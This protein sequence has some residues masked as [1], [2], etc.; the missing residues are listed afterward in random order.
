MA[1]KVDAVTA[2]YGQVEVLHQISITIDTGERVGL[3][4]PN[5]HGKTTLLRAVSGLICPRAGQIHFDSNRIDGVAPKRIVGLGLIHVPQANT[6]FRTMTVLENL[7]LGAYSP[8]AWSE[9]RA[10][11]LRVFELFPLLA[12]RRDQL[13][14]TLSGGE[15]QMLAIGAGLM[16]APTMLMLDEP[17]LGL[18][19]RVKDTLAR[20]I[21][22]IAESG[23]SLLIV[24]Q[25]VELLA[26]LTDRLYL[27]E[28][29][30]IG[31]ETRAGASLDEDKVLEMYFGL[32]P[33]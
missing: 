10:N 2:G 6:L 13:S 31:L 23:V 29:G 18:A 28:Q 21:A 19:P 32:R 15:R 11:L 22:A 20:A 1:L 9:R 16:G 25:D 12:E 8:R 24:D 26:S 14:R 7:T 3:F 33:T 30:R 17:T 27:L 4:G 5:G